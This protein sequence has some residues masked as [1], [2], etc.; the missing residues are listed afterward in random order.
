MTFKILCK[1]GR[2]YSKAIEWVAASIILLVALSM[3]EMIIS[4]TI[5][6]FPWSALDRINVI[7]M[8]WACFLVAGLLVKT[9][10]HITVNYFPAK[11]T[12]LR[13]LFLKLFINI[14]L[15]ATFCIIA[16]Y[17]FLTFRAVY[18]TGVFYPAEIDI[19]QWLA[20]LPICVGMA[21]GIPFVLHI[22]IVNVI[23][24]YRELR[25]RKKAAGDKS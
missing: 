1:I 4:R 12:G 15:L 11:L 14:S 8:I 23:S 17:G 20:S 6:H 24:I 19:P 22:L 3:L 13:L 21:L 5:F 16:Y 10:G 9:E 7:A 18:E 25:N 2:I